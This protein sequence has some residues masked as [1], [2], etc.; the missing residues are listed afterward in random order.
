[1]SAAAL[2]LILF[3]GLGAGGLRNPWVWTV[4]AVISWTAALAEPPRTR[5]AGAWAWACVLAWT[6][7]SALL[8]PEPWLSA[9]A[10]AYA[11]TTCLWLDLGATRG[12]EESRRLGLGLL[13]ALAV[14]AAAAA[15]AVEIESYYSVGLY[16]PYY[17][18]TAALV[19]AAGAAAAAGRGPSAAYGPAAAAVYL[20]LVRSRGGLAGLALGA[21]LALWRSGRR[22]PIA[23]AAA[24]AAVFLAF[25]STSR[26]AILKKGKPGSHQRPAIWR[27][28]LTVAA[29]SPW[30]GEGPGRFARGSL[31]HQTPASASAARS[32]ARYP[33]RADRAHSELFGAAAEVGFVGAGLLLAALLSLLSS[34]RLAAASPP[35]EGLLAAAAALAAQA[36]TDSIFA[37]PALGWLFA[38]CL[39]AAC[40][41]ESRAELPPRPPMRLALAGGLAL[42]SVAWWPGWAVGTWRGTAAEAAL[43]IAPSD[44]G[45][46]QDLARQRLLRGD[47]R[48]ALAALSQ[49]AELAPFS[50]PIRVMAG[51]ILRQV[52]AWSQLR[53][54]A[55]EALTLEPAC[56]QA[57]LQKAEA[58]L[59]LGEPDEAR[60][61]L[62][63]LRTSGALSLE[64]LQDHRDRLILGYDARRLADLNAELQ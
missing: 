63:A 61:T 28:A 30:F 36:A 5:L 3:T 2:P 50:A 22:W 49:A 38:W 23:L 17:N 4:F 39:G 12:D 8:S 31:R 10:F 42:V 9:A 20:L 46:W 47:A 16:F 52:G 41:G 48:G 43:R 6:A 56:G 18:Y 33:L 32:P 45:L 62:E 26:D 29:E 25:P 24:L 55:V 54:V 14:V 58:E 13:W 7:A 40:A 59:R 51:E 44:E 15:S 21:G 53:G 64:R 60:R 37:L 35:Q 34:R 11:A 57:F 27:S 19:A 1:M